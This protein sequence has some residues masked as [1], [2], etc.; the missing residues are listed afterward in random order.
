M[1]TKGLNKGKQV[2]EGAGQEAAGRMVVRGHVEESIQNRLAR[3]W[4]TV[5]ILWGGYYSNG[6]KTYS[7]S[8]RGSAGSGFFPSSS[9]N[10]LSMNKMR[11]SIAMWYVQRR[12]LS[13]GATG[14]IGAQTRLPDELVSLR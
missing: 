7:M 2:E 12:A 3:I 13:A 10:A 4:I 5:R 8:I 9:G 14:S 1:K 11:L 6:G